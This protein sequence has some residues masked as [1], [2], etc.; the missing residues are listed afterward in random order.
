MSAAS[1]RTLLIFV[2]AFFNYPVD[3]SD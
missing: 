1:R 3:T 2:F